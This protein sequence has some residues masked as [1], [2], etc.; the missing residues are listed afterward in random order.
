MVWKA[1]PSM[2]TQTARTPEQQTEGDIAQEYCR[3]TDA[4]GIVEVY[5]LS[6]GTA[7]RLALLL[8]M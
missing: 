3:K 5:I 8:S 4:E 2:A 7:Q 6:E 1:L